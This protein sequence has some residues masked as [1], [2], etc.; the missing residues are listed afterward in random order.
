MFLT[1]GRPYGKVRASRR[2]EVI[3]FERI[4]DGRLVL[5]APSKVA[6]KYINAGKD[7]CGGPPS[8]TRTVN[9]GGNSGGATVDTPYVQIA[10]ELQEQRGPRVGVWLNQARVSSPFGDLTLSPTHFLVE[11]D[12]VAQ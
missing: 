4:H 8:D 5:V 10:G 11:M 12:H 6:W 9:G 7:G 3:L 1:G 2:A